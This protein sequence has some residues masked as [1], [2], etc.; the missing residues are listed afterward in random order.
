MQ[1]AIAARDGD[2]SE[3]AVWSS[4]RPLEGIVV[5]DL[6]RLMPGASATRLLSDFGAQV[7][8]IEEP[9]RGD[10]G[11]WFLPTQGAN[12]IFEL[13][14]RGKKS[15]GLNLKDNRGKDLFLRLV[16]R[17]DVVVESFRPGVMD[18][19]G[20]GA[21]ELLR[22][23]PR[24]IYAALT[25]YG[26]SGPFAHL[27]GHDIN[28][29]A[30]SGLLD[31]MRDDDGQ[32][33]VPPIQIADLAS[34]STQTVI[35]ILLALLSR[36]MTGRGQVVDANMLDGIMPLLVVPLADMMV[37]E[38]QVK[39]SD[40][41]SGTCACYGVYKARDDRWISVGALEPKFWSKVCETLGCEQFVPHQFAGAEK[42][43]EMMATLSRCFAGKD[44]AEWFQ[45]LGSACVAP[46]EKLS[47]DCMGIT[48]RLTGTPGRQG[49]RPP[50][51]G[52]DTREILLAIGLTRQEI[53][54]LAESQVIQT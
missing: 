37:E 6:T 7:V 54:E 45:L 16:S 3:V 20:L 28:Y 52:E 22:H 31:L 15:V 32:P 43:S 30:L 33:S 42:Q 41:L 12:K 10:P 1:V 46:V 19:L 14:N 47:R 9:P 51:L 23:N 21:E 27:P 44:A 17:A 29:L 34:G 5:L 53:D 39:V 49:G 40:L 48:P 4:V 25:G 38:H 24:L 26:R 18:R 35:G 13:T 50:V 36:I 2:S 8:K 11:R